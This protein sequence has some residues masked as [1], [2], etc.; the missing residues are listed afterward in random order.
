MDLEEDVGISEGVWP[1]VSSVQGQ[2]WA[3]Y[4]YYDTFTRSL[5]PGVYYSQRWHTILLCLHPRSIRMQ[6]QVALDGNMLVKTFGAFYGILA[7][8]AALFV[9]P[10]LL[11]WCNDTL[12]L[13]ECEQLISRFEI[14]KFF[15]LSNIL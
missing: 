11:F 7:K 8:T 15:I 10:F 12:L 6:K 2:A 3:C 5:H 1:Q 4:S 14:I 13:H 9:L